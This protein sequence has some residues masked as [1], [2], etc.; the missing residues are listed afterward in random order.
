MTSPSTRDRF[1]TKPVARA[2]TSPSA[3]VATGVGAAI[4]IVATAALSPLL[5]VLGAVV[6]GGV[7]LGARLVAAMPKARDRSATKFN[8]F[9]VEEPWRRAAIDAV[10]AKARFDKAVASFPDGPIKAAAQGIGSQVSRALEQCWKV[11]K[12]GNQLAIARASISDADARRD[13]ARLQAEIGA[14]PPSITQ[15][16]TVDAFQNQIDTADRLDALLVSTN[17][18][19]RLLNARLDESVTRAIELSVSSATSNASASDDDLDATKVGQDIDVIVDDL[20]ALRS[21]IEAV[22]STSAAS[23]SNQFDGLDGTAGQP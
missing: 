7:G 10:R 11:A 23:A 18:Q 13:L 15:A 2:L 21:A 19:L 5:A 3:I 22:D 8:V 9:E 17:Q 20:E 16:R 1:F 12:Q 6:G 14:G 4:G